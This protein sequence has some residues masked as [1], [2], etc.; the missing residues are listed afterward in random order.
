[1]PQCSLLS[2]SLFGSALRWSLFFAL[3][4]SVRQSAMEHVPLIDNYDSDD[5]K[6]NLYDS[7]E[8]DET[9]AKKKKHVIQPVSSRPAHVADDPAAPAS[10]AKSRKRAPSAKPG[11]AAPARP[12]AAGAAAAAASSPAGPLR[13]PRKMTAAERARNQADMQQFLSHDPS[14][15]SPDPFDD[16]TDSDYG[17]D[18]KPKKKPPRAP[19]KKKP[20]PPTSAAA[21]PCRRRGWRLRVGRSCSGTACA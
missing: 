15:C 10:A 1:M 6:Q 12:A 7:D 8:D 20:Q 19:A 4:L 3:C 13:K 17:M 16:P 2:A 9:R 14:I 21:L 18:F 5:P 11:P